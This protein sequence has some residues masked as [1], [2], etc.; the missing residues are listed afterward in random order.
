[1]WFRI[2]RVILTAE[3]YLFIEMTFS[4]LTANGLQIALVRLSDH[5]LSTTYKSYIEDN[6]FLRRRQKCH[7]VAACLGARRATSSAA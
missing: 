5:P 6:C 7:E 1:M 2:K 3:M 4:P